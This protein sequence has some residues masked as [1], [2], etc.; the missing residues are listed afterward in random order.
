MRIAA[1]TAFLVLTIACGGR[2]AQPV[3]DVGGGHNAGQMVL[4]ELRGT[5]DGERLEVRA[6]F[7][8]A[9]QTLRVSL[10]FNVSPPAKLTTGTWNGLGAEGTVRERA[11]TFLGGQNGPPSIGGRFELMGTDGRALYR[12]AIPVQPLRQPL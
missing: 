8:D 12:V 5:R 10:Q 4:R 7:G 6:T 9:G 3:E 2:P 11:V 1:V